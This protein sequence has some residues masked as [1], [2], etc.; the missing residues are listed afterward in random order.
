MEV[1]SMLEGLFSGPRKCL[2]LAVCAVLAICTGPVRAD[3]DKSAE[4]LKRLEQQQK[5]IEELEQRLNA[6]D[7]KEQKTNS[8][9]KEPKKGEENKDG[10]EQS[11]D[12][13]S[14]EQGDAAPAA[15]ANPTAIDDNPI[16][17]IVADYLQQNPGAGMPPGVQTGYSYD[18][19]FAIRSPN[20]PSYMK[21]GDESRIPFE[22]RIRGRIQDDYYFY[23]VTDNF[24]H[25]RERLT[26]P[27]ANN[28]TGFRGANSA[29]DFSQ[30]EI[31]RM[32][33]IFEGTA[34]DPNFRYHIQLDGTTRG[35]AGL[36]GGSGLTGIDNFGAANNDGLNGA[37]NGIATV[38][39]AVRLFA[40]WV[41]YDWRPSWGK[42]GGSPDCPDDTYSYSPVITPFAGKFKPFFS[43]EEVM[44]SANM[45][46]VEYGMSEYYFDSDDDNLQMM[47]GFQVRAF[48]DRLYVQTTL[49]NCNETQTAAIQNQRLPAF[50]MGFWY[51]FGGSWN[52][53]RKAWDLYG[54]SVSDLYYSTKPVIR[55][56]AAT[57]IAPMDRRSLYSNADISR[58][59]VMS[60]DPGGTTLI[61]LLN[62]GNA[63][64][65]NAID[66]VD[67]YKFEYFVTGH[68]KGFSFL[69]DWWVQDLTN[70]QG[71]KNSLGMSN[72]IL[73]NSNRF[74]NTEN[75]TSLFP[76][77]SM[78]DYGFNLAVGYFLVPKKWEVAARWDFISGQ[79]GSPNGNGTFTTTNLPGVGS[80]RVVNGAF[81]T[82]HEA[83]EY[84]VALNRYWRGQM[85]K[86]QTDVGYYRGGNPNIGGVSPSGYIGGVDGYL[87]RTQ[88]QF[89]F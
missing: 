10:K 72:P 86:W 38:D 40:A 16:K 50:N 43:F 9:G 70:F 68:Y 66:S 48:D 29:A 25:L 76:G 65:M 28:P 77:G 64:F 69:N 21:W 30:L 57:Y 1:A 45:Q 67:Q 74:G 32:R 37:G 54:D 15:P 80:V 26:Y 13:E 61:G 51:D 41:A 73:Y 20:N 47:A 82:F 59:K 31:K 36:Q 19:G 56:G 6:K 18:T 7:K 44:G 81:R 23:K 78:Y 60:P 24:D 49:N 79:S 63:G 89:A 42:R 12:A 71:A 2:I 85:L 11:G 52:K 5:K 35:L 17:R 87:I 55:T 27:T 62:G 22:L 4:L 53:E 58:I 8:E 34:F 46:F 84:T 3:D 83:D 39:H 14:Q 75:V 88:I 33:L